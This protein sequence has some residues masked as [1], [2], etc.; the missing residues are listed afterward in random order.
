LKSAIKG[1][2]EA[3]DEYRHAAQML[4]T[5][6]YLM[7]EAHQ[8]AIQIYREA[9]SEPWFI[10]ISSGYKLSQI[11]QVVNNAF[12][13]YFQF[14]EMLGVVFQKVPMY[15]QD[16]LFYYEAPESEWW[17]ET[18]PIFTAPYWVHLAETARTGAFLALGPAV[19]VENT[20]SLI[21]GNV[22]TSLEQLKMSLESPERLDA[23][24]ALCRATLLDFEVFGRPL[25]R[26][27][28]MLSAAYRKLEEAGFKV[29]VPRTVLNTSGVTRD[30]EQLSFQE[31]RSSDDAEAFLQNVSRIPWYEDHGPDVCG[32]EAP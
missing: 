11:T 14:Q 7:R 30:T 29:R 6:R 15:I 26:F 1:P 2:F 31:V 17:E 25:L 24:Q 8:A 23:A 27:G 12:N 20:G 5:A 13:A 4:W 32:G 22:Y 21:W 10:P 3:E 18:T 19:T 28:V 16:A 9:K